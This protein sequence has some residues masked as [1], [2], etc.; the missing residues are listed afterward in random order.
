MK[1]YTPLAK[2][3]C[4]CGHTGDGLLS[5]HEDNLLAKGHGACKECDCQKFTWKEF[6][7]KEE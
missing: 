6:I 2:S 3:V 7:K 5:E 4:I 1:E